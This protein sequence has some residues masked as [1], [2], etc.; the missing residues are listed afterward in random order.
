MR[1][2]LA[3]DADFRAAYDEARAALFQVA[4][5][6]VQALLARAVAELAIQ[7]YDA[8]IILRKLDEIEAVQRELCELSADG[9]REPATA[10]VLKMGC[11]V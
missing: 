2:W 10:I 7:Q 8:D 1:R 4:M 11:G 5:S 6:R 3:E 9:C